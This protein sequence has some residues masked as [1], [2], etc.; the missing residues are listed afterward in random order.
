MALEGDLER[1][2]V[3]GPDLLDEP[4]VPDQAEQTLGTATTAG[5]VGCAGKLR[6]RQRR[7]AHENAVGTDRFAHYFRTSALVMRSQGMYKTISAIALVG[8]LALPSGAIAKPQDA[9]KRAAIAQCKDERG[10][11]RATREAFKAN[12]HSFS[13]CVSRKTAEEESEETTAHKN[14]AKACKAERDADP[15]AFQQAYGDNENGQ[16]TY[17]KCVSSKA[18]QKKAEMDAEDE[19][20]VEARKKAAKECAGEREDKGREAFVE[21]YGGKRNAFG[22]CVSSKARDEGA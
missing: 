5:N 4:V 19:Q 22:K 14:A 17:G 7:I 20:Q 13:R 9:Q 3:P 10:K 18:K 12:Y 15:V 16:N 8:A 6:N 1:R 21:A 11:S 2:F